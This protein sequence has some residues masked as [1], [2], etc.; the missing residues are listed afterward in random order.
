[1]CC[2]RPHAERRNAAFTTVSFCNSS[3]IFT[4]VIRR[5]KGSDFANIY[6][7]PCIQVRRRVAVPRGREHRT[8]LSPIKNQSQA[9]SPFTRDAVAAKRAPAVVAAKTTGLGAFQQ[10]S[11]PAAVVKIGSQAAQAAQ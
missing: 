7:H 3:R 8:T 11:G 5:E 10:S 1:M 9:L 2:A 6:F 4:G